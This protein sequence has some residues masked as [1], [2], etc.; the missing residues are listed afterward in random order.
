MRIKNGDES[1][2]LL[3]FVNEIEDISGVTAKSIEPRDDEFTEKV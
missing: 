3:A 1:A 2:T